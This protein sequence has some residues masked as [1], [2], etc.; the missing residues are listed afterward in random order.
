MHCR[1]F[2]VLLADDKESIA[3]LTAR[4]YINRYSLEHK[5]LI[6]NSKGIFYTLNE[7]YGNSFVHQSC[8]MVSLL[9]VF[10]FQFEGQ[11]PVGYNLNRNLGYAAEW[12]KLNT[13][14]QRSVEHGFWQFYNRIE[15]LFNDLSYPSSSNR[16][17]RFKGQ[18][19]TMDNI[20]IYLYMFVGGHCLAAL[21]FLGENLVFFMARSSERKVR[22]TLSH[23]K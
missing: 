16:K 22:S 5:E 8:G 6:K 3:F 7:I 20:W 9:C 21:V 10:L 13:I 15:L 4:S 1:I 18:A 19:I 23:L 14:I 2:S 12:N 11:T 17:Q